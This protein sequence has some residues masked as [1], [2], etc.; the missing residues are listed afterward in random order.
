MLKQNSYTS[1]ATPDAVAD[2]GAAIAWERRYL[3]V[4]DAN[5][6]LAFEK[7]I[8]IALCT[9]SEHDHTKLRIEAGLEE[10]APVHYA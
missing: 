4:S 5:S 2:K 10:P 8:L 1:R 3:E 9:M 6:K 7:Q